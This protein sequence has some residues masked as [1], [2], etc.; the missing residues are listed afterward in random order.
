MA[1]PAAPPPGQPVVGAIPAT[2]A[3]TPVTAVPTGASRP[4]PP[5]S[6]TTARRVRLSAM[7]AELDAALRAVGVEI[8]LQAADYQDGEV[9]I[10]W[11]VV[12][13][14]DGTP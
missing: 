13:P 6:P 3:G 14:A 2:H 9:E 12:G 11:H 10:S 5:P 7:E 4:E 1:S 8:R